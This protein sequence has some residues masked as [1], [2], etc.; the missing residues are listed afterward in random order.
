MNYKTQ[1]L[2]LCAVICTGFVFNVSA[3]DTCA[4]INWKAATLERLTTVGAAC[5][6][7]VDRDGRKYARMEAT[8]AGQSPAGPVVRYTHSDGSYGSMVRT[9]P[10]EGFV[11]Q[12]EGRDV[13]L[14]DL[15]DG[16]VVNVY[17]P[18]SA[19]HIPEPEVAAP[20]V[21]AAPPPPPPPAPEPEPEPEPDPVMPVTA[22]S[23]PLLALFGAL[24][25]VLG[26]ALRYA[27]KQ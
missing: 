8:I 2:A 16:Q 23:L 12:I 18:D 20:A 11:A 22:G 27:R 21:A 13:D 3:Q 26:G 10:P 6:E 1:K 4:D 17:L 9:Y 14:G 19:W 24:F 5:L 7:V 15:D 25:L